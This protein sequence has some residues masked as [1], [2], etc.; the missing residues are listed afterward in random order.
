MLFR[1]EK[2]PASR[3]FRRGVTFAEKPELEE[4]TPREERATGGRIARG[5]TANSLISAVERARKAEQ[6]TTKSILN[7]PDESVV[8][9]LKIA[10]SSI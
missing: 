9:A 6:N 10:K 5:M 4:E 1:S 3:V 8:H 2:H 7:H